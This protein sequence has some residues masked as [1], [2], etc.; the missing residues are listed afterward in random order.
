MKTNFIQDINKNNK[1]TRSLTRI[2]WANMSEHKQPEI[3]Y[4]EIVSLAE[5]YYSLGE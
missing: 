2:V 4:F 3:A 5:R 1:S